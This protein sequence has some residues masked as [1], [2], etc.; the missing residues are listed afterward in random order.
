MN[1]AKPHCRPKIVGEV[2]WTLELKAL[3]KDVNRLRRRKQRT[4]KKTL[5]ILEARILEYKDVCKALG[6]ALLCA[7]VEAWRDLCCSLN[8]DTW[9]CPYKIVM[10]RLKAKLPSPNLCKRM[11][12]NVLKLCFLFRLMRIFVRFLCMGLNIP[13]DS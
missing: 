2:G 11:A 1:K 3:R 5:E 13:F 10:V 12:E 6:I 7:R 8:D 4:Y 9:G